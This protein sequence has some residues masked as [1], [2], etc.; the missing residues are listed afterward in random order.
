M[1]KQAL[2]KQL[3]RAMGY[4]RTLNKFLQYAENF[5]LKKITK[6]RWYMLASIGDKVFKV[7]GIQEENTISFGILDDRYIF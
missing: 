7:V 1:E 6:N 3:I 2:E 5:V 4:F